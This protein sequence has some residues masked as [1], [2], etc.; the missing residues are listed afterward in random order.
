[1]SRPPLVL[2]LAEV[3]PQLPLADIVTVCAAA[4]G[5]ASRTQEYETPYMN[6]S[7]FIRRAR[8][9]AKKTERTIRF[10]PRQ[11]KGSHG[12]LY[13]GDRRTTVKRGEL[14]PGTLHSMLRQPNIPKEDF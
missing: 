3:P 5:L 6:S 4:G 7:E 13:V 9:Y 10:D 1:M 8:R 11:G 14:K 2:Q 12:A